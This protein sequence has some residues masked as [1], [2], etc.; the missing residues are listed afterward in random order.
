MQCSGEANYPLHI[1]LAELLR[2][3]V[4][5]FSGYMIDDE[6]KMGMYQIGGTTWR[7]APTQQRLYAHTIQMQT[8]NTVNNVAWIYRPWLQANFHCAASVLAIRLTFEWIEKMS[9][10]NILNMT[11]STGVHTASFIIYYAYAR[12]DVLLW[13]LQYPYAPGW[14]GEF[15]AIA[16][17]A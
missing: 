6:M 8:M 12:C 5:L 1:R 17:I 4:L 16:S 3:T 10:S 15:W 11:F 2:V 13:K 9:P 14:I 7:A